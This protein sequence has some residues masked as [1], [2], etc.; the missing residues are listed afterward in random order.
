M[1]GGLT[2]SPGLEYRVPQSQYAYWAGP[3][4]L[5]KQAHIA[6][7]PRRFFMPSALSSMAVGSGHPSGWPVP[8]PVLVTHCQPSPNQPLTERDGLQTK[9]ESEMSAITPQGEIRPISLQ[10]ALKRLR[11]HLAKIGFSLQKTR[12]G[13]PAW[14]LHG[15]YAIRDDRGNI[16]ADRLSLEARLRAYG[17]MA[18]IEV[19]L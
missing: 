14:R 19:I 16:H 1:I 9:Q 15:D 6:P 10:T 8:V 2:V 18:D 13:S 11:R 4:T 17:L 3:L 12:P 7:F 5:S